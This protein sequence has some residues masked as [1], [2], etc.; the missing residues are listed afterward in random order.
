MSA[1]FCNRNDVKLYMFRVMVKIYYSIQL[2]VF[3]VCGNSDT[4]DKHV[5]VKHNL[6]WLRRPLT[7]VKRVVPIIRL[8]S[9]PSCEEWRGCFSSPPITIQPFTSIL[10]D[11]PCTL[12]SNWKEHTLKQ[13]IH[14][15]ELCKYS[16][17][18]LSVTWK[19][20]YQFSC[21]FF[22]FWGLVPF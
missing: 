8:P 18:D 1:C 6:H 13:C 4:H 9:I 7:P 21:I 17:F 5:D 11:G 10:R 22:R 12:H 20:I 16:S 19:Y 15:L 14:V 2:L 3:A